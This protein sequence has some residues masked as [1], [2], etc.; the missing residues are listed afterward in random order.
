VFGLILSKVFSVYLVKMEDD[1][2]VLDE[3]NSMIN[4]K[5]NYSK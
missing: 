5:R 3:K 2:K 4:Q 1:E